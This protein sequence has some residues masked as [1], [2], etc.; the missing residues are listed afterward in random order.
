MTGGYYGNRLYRNHLHLKQENARLQQKEKQ[1]EALR[2][3]VERIR[4]DEKIVRS[5]LG[6]DTEKAEENTLGQ[7]GVPSTDLSKVDHR[8]AMLNAAV[9]LPVKVRESS[10]LAVAENLAAKLKEL[11]GTMHDQRKLWRDTPSVMPVD[12][13]SYWL[14]SGF[15]WRN[16]PFTGRK[17]FHN[18]LDIC[19]GKGTAIIAPADGMVL[20]KGRDKYLGN[21]IKI[22][23]GRG[24]KTIYGHLSKIHVRTKEKV[25]RGDAIG[26]M[27][28]TGLSTGNHLH[29]VVKLNN[30][31]MNPLHYIL[32]AKDN[33]LLL[34]P[35]SAKG[36]NQ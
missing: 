34:H 21:Y 33:S 11:L 3:T 5:F 15:G 10:S 28:S 27:G 8:D 12:T 1:L 24:I 14:S 20:K 30:K 35:L 18:G 2:Q 25:N 22:D 7:G 19:G 36:G 4:K 16:S 32:N 26:I 17:E 13:S 29:Y 23:H 6:L 9:P 31:F